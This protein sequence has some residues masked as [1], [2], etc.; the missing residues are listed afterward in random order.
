MTSSSAASTDRGSKAS[1]TLLA[2]FSAMG[3]PASHGLTAPGWA[4]RLQR[5]DGVA[6]PPDL[7]VEV[8]A[9]GPAGAPGEPDHVALLHRGARRHPQR[10]EV[11]VAGPHPAAV[12]HLHVVPVAIAV[13]S[14]DHHAVAG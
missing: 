14:A 8:R 3:L 4:K 1:T 6:V 9:G 13:L 7:E 11:A 10:G 12:V 2:S 5:V